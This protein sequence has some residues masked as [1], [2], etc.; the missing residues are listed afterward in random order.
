[1]KRYFSI[2][3]LLLKLSWSLFFS[4]RSNLF[5]GIFTSLVWSSLVI[6]SIFAI[7]SRSPTVLG[8]TQNELLLLSA[9]Y[10][11]FFGIYY[12]LFNTNFRKFSQIIFL[13]E[14]DNFL[15]KPIDAQFLISS[16]QVS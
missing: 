5:S 10:N 15:L 12:F 2:Y 13:G 7:T 4:N 6:I 8:W 16:Q 11:I 9:T 14:L 1:M 3:L